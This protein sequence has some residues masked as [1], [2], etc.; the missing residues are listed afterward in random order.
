[1]KL[2]FTTKIHQWGN[3]AGIRIRK[4]FMEAAGWQDGQELLMTYDDRDRS[5]KLKAVQDVAKA[6]Q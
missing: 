1:M 4:Q 6:D 5:I 2:M 3:T